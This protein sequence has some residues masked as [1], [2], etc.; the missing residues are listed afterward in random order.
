MYDYSNR[1]YENYK[2]P[3]PIE[4]PSRIVNFLHVFLL[5]PGSSH[6]EHTC[7]LWTFCIG[8][9]PSPASLRFCRFPRFLGTGGGSTTISLNGLSKSRFVG[10]VVY[11]SRRVISIARSP[12][13]TIMSSL[14]SFWPCDK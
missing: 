8:P 14:N 13:C 12:I 5:C 9:F 4:S 1:Q 10:L 3:S 7:G 2:I 6:N 11:S